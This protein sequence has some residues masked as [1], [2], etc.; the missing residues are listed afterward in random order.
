MTERLGG[1]RLRLDDRRSEPDEQRTRERLIGVAAGFIVLSLS[2]VIGMDAA[3]GLLVLFIVGG[4]VVLAARRSRAGTVRA[5]AQGIGP[6]SLPGVLAELSRTS[7]GYLIRAHGRPG[8]AAEKDIHVRSADLM[9]AL[10][11]YQVTIDPRWT[12]LDIGNQLAVDAPGTITRVMDAYRHRPP[13]RERDVAIEIL[14]AYV[15]Q[16]P[17]VARNVYTTF[18]GVALRHP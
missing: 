6:S 2:F 17:A 14:R 12:D 9:A 4:L 5:T 10:R 7:R 18:A 1:A 15:P 13:S 16:G 11:F 3:C 8:S